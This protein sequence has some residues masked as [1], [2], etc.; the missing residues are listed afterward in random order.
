MDIS[1]QDNIGLVNTA[2]LC[3]LIKVCA[4]N[5]VSLF[6]FG[7]IKLEFGKIDQSSKTKNILAQTSADETKATKIKEEAERKLSLEQ[8]QQDVEELKLSN[9]LAYEQFIEGEL[10]D[11]GGGRSEA[12]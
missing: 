7:G 5:K 4:K 12:T 6:N 8:L 2:E 1:I 11:A 9:P 10:G 3:Q